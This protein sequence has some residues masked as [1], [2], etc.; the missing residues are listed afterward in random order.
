MYPSD[1]LLRDDLTQAHAVAWGRIGTA[2]DFFTGPQRVEMVRAAR[3]ALACRLCAARKSALSPNAVA[4][5]HQGSA[6]LD[7][8]ILELI[9]RLATDPGRLTRAWFDGVLE[10]GVSRQGYVEVVSVVTSSVIID[11]LHRALGLERPT[12]PSPQPGEPRGEYDTTAV[13]AG[14]WLPILDA[15]ADMGS[16]GLPRVPNIVRALG[17]VPSALE[18]FF[19]TFRPHYALQAIPLSISQTQAEFVAA[20]VSA[21]NECFY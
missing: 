11:T 16:A 10:R 4:G 18:L 1:S 17:L 15:P 12:L 20:R 21:I 2:G 13:D 19:D 8:P 5:A 6:K 9:H 14:A 3:E 7:D